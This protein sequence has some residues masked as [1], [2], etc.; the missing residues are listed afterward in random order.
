MMKDYIKSFDEFVNE[1]F[2]NGNELLQAFKKYGFK[3]DRNFDGLY[4]QVGP[5]ELIIRH[6]D[7][8]EEI[9]D[10]TL[11]IDLDNNTIALFGEEK[12]K[13]VLADGLIQKIENYES[14]PKAVD[15]F[16]TKAGFIEV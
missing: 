2:E 1:R 16:L 12:I 10:T 3:L 9:E 14:D 7:K 11:A 4:L 13:K 15:K 5:A 6:A 8:A